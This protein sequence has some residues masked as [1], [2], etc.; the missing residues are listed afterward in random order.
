[1]IMRDIKIQILPYQERYQQEIDFL[2]DSIAKE[3]IEPISTE[4]IA[5]S[6]LQPDMYLVAMIENKVVG[7]ISVTKLKNNNSVLRK[8]FLHKYYR[9]QGIAEL[10]FQRVINWAND[11]DVKSIYLGTMAQF[12]IAQKFYKRLN[13]EQINKEILPT[14]FPLNPVDSI[15]YKL[16][17]IQSSK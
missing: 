2:M 3:F 15:F 7:T 12:T 6:I 17:L 4:S 9:G 5:K 8:M 13:F 16:N 1:M 11:N 10:L 14:D